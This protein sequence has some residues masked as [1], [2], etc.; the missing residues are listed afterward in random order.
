MI[1]SEQGGI[2]IISN[3]YFDASKGLNDVKSIY[4]SKIN[5]NGEDIIEFVPNVD[6]PEVIEKKYFI[7]D[8]LFYNITDKYFI[9]SQLND[10]IGQSVLKKKHGALFTNKDKGLP[11]FS[12]RKDLTDT[13]LFGKKYKRFEINGWE[14]YTIYY[15]H[16]TDTIIPYTIYEKEGRKYKGRIERIDSYHKEKDI[17]IS[18]QLI[19]RKKWDNEAKE[20]FE[21]NDF[22]NKRYKNSNRK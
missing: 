22:V 16:P 12:W 19:I 10:S 21:Y 11:N 4:L 9:F 5:Y 17:F 6:F 8:S 2:D 14:S 20:I 18:L 1:R 13:I 7:K 3:F 15:I